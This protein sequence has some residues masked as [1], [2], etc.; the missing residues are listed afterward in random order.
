MGWGELLAFGLPLPKL[1]NTLPTPA[2]VVG[3]QQTESTNTSCKQWL[4]LVKIVLKVSLADR[5]RS[6]VASTS[7]CGEGI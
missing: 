2:G 6:L 1:N 4:S 3:H 5:N 7:R